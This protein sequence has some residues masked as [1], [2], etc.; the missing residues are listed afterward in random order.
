MEKNK[1]RISFFIGN[2]AG[3]GGTERVTILL[4]RLLSD[5]YDVYFISLSLSRTMSMPF[6]KE[7]DV[8]GVES[9]VKDYFNINKAIRRHVIEN[10]IDVIINVDSILSIFSIPALFGCKCKNICWEHFN[11]KT[12]AFS[13]Y[14]PWARNLAK[15]LSDKI[16]VLTERDRHYWNNDKVVTICN[17]TPYQDPIVK[18][19]DLRK[20]RVLAVGRL[21]KQKGLE[22]LITIW[23]I[24]E[25]KIV[26]LDFSL[27]IIGD[28]ELKGDLLQLINDNN[29]K[30]IKLIPFSSNIDDIYLDSAIYVMTSYFEGLP[31]VLIEA[32]SFGMPIV[33]FDID[34]GPSDI[35]EHGVNGYLIDDGDLESFAD[36]LIHLMKSPEMISKMSK[37][38]LTKRKSYGE[39][40]ILK[41]WKSVINDIVLQ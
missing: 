38:S 6:A 30:K 24:V 3:S 8:I 39:D 25:K 37:A 40:A 16:I 13:R 14:R 35:I 21:T 2:L 23:S 7:I 27:E 18:S 15:L 10:E 29:L 41:K 28:G 20:K 9:G 22:R 32:L 31:M 33:S 11:Y 36:N 34:C 12:N 1:K 19:V 26:D 4:A 17:P 5:D